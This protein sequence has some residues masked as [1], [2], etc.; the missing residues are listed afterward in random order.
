MHAKCCARSLLL[1]YM[2]AL[3]EMKKLDSRL[4][5]AGMTSLR[6]SGFCDSLAGGWADKRSSNLEQMAFCGLPKCP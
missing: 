5:H 3:R 2:M 4:K 1:H 6:I